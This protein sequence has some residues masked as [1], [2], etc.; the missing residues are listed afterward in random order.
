MYVYIYIIHI[1]I[2]IYYEETRQV[3]LIVC[4]IAYI[5][6]SSICNIPS[7]NQLTKSKTDFR[8]SDPIQG[9]NH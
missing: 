3:G 6:M 7:S 1:Y 4:H 8:H 2:Y 5:S 9:I